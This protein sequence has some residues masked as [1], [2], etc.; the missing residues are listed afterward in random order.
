MSTI[1]TRQR[2]ILIVE[3]EGDMCLLIEIILQSQDVK[4]SHVKNLSEAKAFIEEE[5][6]DLILLDNRLPDG[7]GVDFIGVIKQNYP[8]VKIILITGIDLAAQ[9]F[10]LEAGADTFLAK[11]FNQQQL[12]QAIRSLLNP[13][14]GL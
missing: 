1:I 2:H 5:E 11:P 3:D 13:V 9:D 4:I 7:F 12:R 14:K 6:P 8:N 10:A